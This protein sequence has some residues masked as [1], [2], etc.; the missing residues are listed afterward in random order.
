MSLLSK[1]KP[2]LQKRV[3]E[4]ELLGKELHLKSN[5][6]EKVNAALIKLKKQLQIL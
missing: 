4:R 2:D 3:K 6:K 1:G 5:V